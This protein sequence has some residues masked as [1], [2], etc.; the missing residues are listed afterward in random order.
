MGT[1]AAHGQATH[2]AQE[3]KENKPDIKKADAAHGHGPQEGKKRRASQARRR[4]SPAT[5]GDCIMAVVGGE[6]AGSNGT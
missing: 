3:G 6:G 5:V 4:Y 1:G 2:G